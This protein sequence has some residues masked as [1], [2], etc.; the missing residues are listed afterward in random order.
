MTRRGQ[1]NVT[2]LDL[3]PNW[4]CQFEFVAAAACTMHEPTG[5]RRK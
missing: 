1:S 3:A 4:H 2:G 5:R